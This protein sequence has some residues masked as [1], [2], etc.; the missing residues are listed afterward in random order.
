MLNEIPFRMV[1]QHMTIP[2]ETGSG[3]TYTDADR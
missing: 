1:E 3:K 2:R